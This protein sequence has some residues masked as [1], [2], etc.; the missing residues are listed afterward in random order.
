[1]AQFERGSFTLTKRSGSKGEQQG[2][3]EVQG[4]VVVGLAFRWRLPTPASLAATKVGVGPVHQRSLSIRPVRAP[5]HAAQ[6]GSEPP[7]RCFRTRAA[8]VTLVSTVQVVRRV[9]DARWAPY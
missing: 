4:H 3:M 8:Q 5:Q 9:R 2:P 7:H 1:M 6:Q